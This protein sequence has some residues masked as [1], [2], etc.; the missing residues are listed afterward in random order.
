MRPPT[1][2]TPPANPAQP[3]AGGVTTS[4]EPTQ[5]EPPAPNAIPRFT[6]L[7]DLQDDPA[8]ALLNKHLTVLKITKKIMV[9]N[10][11]QVKAGEDLLQAAENAIQEADYIL[12]LISSHIFNEDGLWLGYA[13]GALEQGK[14][15]IPIKV[16]HA[17]LEGTGL[18]RLRGL[19]SMNRS[20]SDFP[21]PD[22][23]WKDVVEEI[24]RLIKP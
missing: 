5:P 18:E 9:Y 23:A 20:V 12:V 19:P 22:A 8:A 7:Y 21:N 2:T 11:H 15:I 4:T 3:H 16:N 6:L 14:K 10:V 24:K 17:D 1:T 13:L